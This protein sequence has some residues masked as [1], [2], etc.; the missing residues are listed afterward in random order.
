M[1]LFGNPK[2]SANRAHR[3]GQKGEAQA[4][5]YLKKQGY[6][7]IES[8]FRCKAGE[9]DLV[10]RKGEFLVFVEVKTRV[11]QNPLIQMTQAKCAQVRKLAQIYLMEKEISDLQPRF[12]VIAITETSQGTELEHVENAF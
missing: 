3:L 11:D 12:D 8:N 2:L 4:K 5:K 7:I 6:K 9:L 1:S 10:V